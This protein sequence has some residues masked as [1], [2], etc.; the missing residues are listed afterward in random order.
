MDSK[1]RDV[2]II[3]HKNPDTDSICSAIAYAELK[4]E[5]VGPGFEACR[6]GELNRETAFVL[7]K[8]NTRPP[9]FCQDVFAEVQDIDIRPVQGVP[10]DTSMRRA[11]ELMRDNEA[12]TQPIVS[13]DGELLGISTLGDLAK[14][15]MDNLQPDIVSQAKTPVEN[16]MSVLNATMICGDDKGIIEKGKIIVG[17]AS[18][19]LMET[20]IDPGDIVIVGNRYEAQ[21]RAIEMGASLIIVCNGA[22]VARIIRR[23]A[24]ENDCIIMTT[25]YDSF[26][27]ANLIRQRDRKSVV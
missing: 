25:P 22:S 14:A 15:N 24:M 1:K 11:W 23:L 16:I 4:K 5:T 2:I 10:A 7:E 6:A 3:G 26:A 19:E 12:K 8:F 27:T 9:R 21:I 17:A 20:K 13:E 18:P